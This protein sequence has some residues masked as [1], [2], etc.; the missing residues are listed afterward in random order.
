MRKTVLIFAFLIATLSYGQ[1]MKVSGRSIKN[2]KDI[3]EFNLEF[4]YS[5]LQIQHYGSKDVS[6][7]AFRISECYAKLAK[8]IAFYIIKK[9]K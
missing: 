8:N 2:L 5:N 1:N 7:S 4:D 3:T 6:I 9:A